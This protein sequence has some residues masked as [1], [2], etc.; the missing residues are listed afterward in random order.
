MGN[1]NMNDKCRKKW[2]EVNK[3]IWDNVGAV[4]LKTH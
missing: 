3:W 1:N 2:K 4:I